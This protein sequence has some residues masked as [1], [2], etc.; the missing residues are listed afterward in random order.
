MEKGKFVWVVDRKDGK[1]YKC[2]IIQVKEE[3]LKIHYHGWN[4]TH[5]EWIEKSSER[6][7][8][9]AESSQACPNLNDSVQSAEMLIDSLSESISA[10][11]AA[12][13]DS[14][15]EAPVVDVVRGPGRDL[16]G[17]AGRKRDRGSESPGNDHG[18]CRRKRHSIH[19]LNE[20]DTGDSSSIGDAVEPSGADAAGSS[21]GDSGAVERRVLLRPGL[22]SS[23]V[24][25]D[26]TPLTATGGSN[27]PSG[28]VVGRGAAVP[29]VPGSIVQ[30][31]LCCLAMGS[32]SVKCNS[33]VRVFHPEIS[34]LGVDTKTIEVLLAD[35]NGAISYK[36]CICRSD[37]SEGSILPDSSAMSQLVAMVGELA[38]EIKTMKSG[39][40][41]Q[42]G[43]SAETNSVSRQEVFVQVRELREREKRSD[44]IILRGFNTESVSAVGAKFSEICE[45]LNV[46]AVPLV[47]IQRVGDTR[48]FRARISDAEKR[49]NLLLKVH[50]L[51]NTENF[52]RV[53]IHRDLT[54]Q[55]RQDLEARRRTVRS[56]EV[57]TNGNGTL[58]SSV[59]TGSNM[60]N[61]SV[62]E[63]DPSSQSIRGRRIS[64]T[65]LNP[66]TRSRFGSSSSRGRGRNG[67]NRSVS[68]AN[69]AESHSV[70]GIGRIPHIRRNLNA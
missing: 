58:Y 68:Q 8:G 51:R 59:L 70:N 46:E 18:N 15:G 6:L 47:D 52:S 62:R 4:A 41:I 66:P 53:Y 12:N 7:M 56:S 20:A 39:Y 21:S 22:S 43:V 63:G 30:C 28:G 60:V 3:L 29:G 65:R 38:R 55:Q 67:M 36:C 45:T 19:V 40:R 2:K 23:A 32:S 44:S 25:L 48:L 35:T 64:R 57:P 5:D 14:H 13:L 54:Y 17:G 24:Q 61:V 50:E 1:E 27:M 11:D 10:R 33:C 31:G 34:C 26:R 49:R 16:G 42:Q 69:R 37:T 9:G